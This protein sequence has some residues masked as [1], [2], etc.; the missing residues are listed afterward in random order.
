MIVAARSMD[1]R[2]PSPRFLPPPPQ[3]YVFASR[4]ILIYKN[5]FSQT[6]AIPASLCLAADLK[7][8]L[9]RL[10]SSEVMLYNRLLPN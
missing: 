8:F 9:M 4:K 5:N 3:T 6:V 2:H 1:R 7:G 10:F